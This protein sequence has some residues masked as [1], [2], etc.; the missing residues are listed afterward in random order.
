MSS[1]GASPL[2]PAFVPDDA[3]S[4][5]PIPSG[6]GV[7]RHQSL[8]YGPNHNTGANLRRT[9]TTAG[10]K[11]RRNNT[12]GVGTDAPSGSTVP[13]SP[14]PDPEEHFVEEEA[15]VEEQILPQMP[16][17]QQPQPQIYASNSGGRSPWSTPG[18]PEWRG[19]NILTSSNNTYMP[20]NNTSASMI[21]DV[22]RALSTLELSSA[23]TS[24]RVVP[25]IIPMNNAQQGIG[26]PPRFAN[27]NTAGAKGMNL[28]G[29]GLRSS[30]SRS[31]SDLNAQLGSSLFRSTEMPNVGGVGLQN[32]YGANS[33]VSPIGHGTSVQQSNNRMVGSMG[34][35]LRQG[36]DDEQGSSG[37][38]V[39]EHRA[40]TPRSSNPNL[41]NQN[42]PHQ[43][44][45]VPP[46]VPS[47]P[48]QY[49]QP[50]QAQP[51]HQQAPRL[52]GMNY[53]GQQAG[54]S[55][56]NPP[57]N[58]AYLGSPIDVPTL[59]KTKGYNP[60]TFDIRPSFARYFVIKSYTEDDVHKSLKYEIWSST[61]PGN[62]RL[63]KAF[64]EVN[65]RGPIYLFF[66]VNARYVLSFIIEMDDVKVNLAG[67]F[68]AWRKCLRRWIIREV[69]RFGHPTSGKVFSKFAGYL[70]ETFRMRIFVISA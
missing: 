43:N 46:P 45:V 18:P 32:P 61:D 41:Q 69:A 6:A 8:T 21:D 42:Q 33:Y 1:A 40:L 50:S 39:W 36:V 58:P 28:H 63:D 29:N 20:G 57:G 7:R 37:T 64:K 51:Q 11:P 48:Q 44:W 62:K 2:S 17:L 35:M 54:N 24:P 70:S 30:D 3:P 27:Q 34:G 16:S 4:P 60:T 31:V 59:I 15:E 56:L 52:A 22:Q 65:G 55:G 10:I 5:P 14:S 67:T 53:S 13:E 49:L 26:Q 25:Q 68:A 19:A 38:G 66:S 47:I 23:G 9:G 12:I